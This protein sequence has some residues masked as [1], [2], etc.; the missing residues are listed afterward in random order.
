M[1]LHAKC[2]QY[3]FF[4]QRVHC[5]YIHFYK[6]FKQR[7][8]VFSLKQTPF[9]KSKLWFFSNCL[10]LF[11]EED[12]RKENRSNIKS[13]DYKGFVYHLLS[14]HSC[15]ST[16]VKYFTLPVLNLMKIKD[17]NSRRPL[18]AN[19]RISKTAMT[20]TKINTTTATTAI[21]ELLFSSNE[22]IMVL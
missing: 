6:G 5:K 2:I 19:F 14:N 3:N 13:F 10:G 7:Y 8:S 9:M 18:A 21:S 11:H 22:S 4:L 17:N 16:C 1:L 12:E 20:P 15:K